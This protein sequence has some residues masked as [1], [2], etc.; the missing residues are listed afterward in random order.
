[1]STLHIRVVQ[2]NVVERECGR[3]SRGSTDGYPR[4]LNLGRAGD[5]GAG[6]AVSSPQ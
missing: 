5:S 4:Q 1:M 2:T 3:G 6:A